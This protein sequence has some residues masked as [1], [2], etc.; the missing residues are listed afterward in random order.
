M[1]Y[2]FPGE[3]STTHKGGWTQKT[4]EDFLSF[5][6]KRGINIITIW[7]NSGLATPQKATTCA[8]VFPTLR[9]WVTAPV[10]ESRP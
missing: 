1:A 6:G 9:A 10:T 5:V 3:G 2:L 7:S 8:W 4:L